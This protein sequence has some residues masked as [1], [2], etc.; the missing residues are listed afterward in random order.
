MKK[1][2]LFVFSILI[3]FAAEAQVNKKFC[4]VTA[5]KRVVTPVIQG[6]AD[7]TLGT[8]YSNC[9]ISDQDVKVIG[10]EVAS[11]VIDKYFMI[12]DAACVGVT[13]KAV[14]ANE[15]AGSTFIHFIPLPPL[16]LTTG[17]TIAEIV[18]VPILKVKNVQH[19]KLDTATIRSLLRIKY[20]PAVYLESFTSGEI[21][22]W[23]MT[24]E[25]GIPCYIYPNSTQ[26]GIV[27]S[28]TKP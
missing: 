19:L 2:I 8:Q 20:S 27:V 10:Q 15:I 21:T 7:T 26:D 17:F 16:D 13:Y 24:N 23:I 6:L 11:Q 28:E 18:S 14:L 22:G 1:I 25:R 12:K 3:C 5:T 9:Q 4:K